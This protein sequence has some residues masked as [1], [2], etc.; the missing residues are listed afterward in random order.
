MG[1]ERPYV[2]SGGGLK[3]WAAAHKIGQAYNAVGLTA[4]VALNVVDLDPDGLFDIPTK[5]FVIRA[6]G[7]YMIGIR[8]L[9]T[10]PGVQTSPILRARVNGTDVVLSA[11]YCLALGLPTGR[12]AATHLGSS[13]PLALVAG[14]VIDLFA[15]NGSSSNVS[16]DGSLWITRLD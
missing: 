1:F 9:W 7:I 10:V 4:Q 13:D 14:D 6:D 16:L 15:F 3:L 12:V 8:G 5:S 11:A 2:I